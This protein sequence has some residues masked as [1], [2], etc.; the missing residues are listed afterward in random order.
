MLVVGVGFYCCGVLMI[1]NFVLVLVGTV[2]QLLVYVGAGLDFLDYFVYLF[3][4]GGDVAVSWIHSKV[5]GDW[6]GLCWLFRWFLHLLGLY[7]DCF[8]PLIVGRKI[9]SPIFDTLKYLIFSLPNLWLSFSLYFYLMRSRN[10]HFILISFPFLSFMPYLI[11]IIKPIS[12][13]TSILTFICCLS[14]HIGFY[15]MSFLLV[16]FIVIMKTI[17]WF[18]LYFIDLFEYVIS[19]LLAL[20]L[21]LSA[22]VHFDKLVL[23][24]LKVLVLLKDGCFVCLDLLWAEIDV[25]LVWG[26]SLLGCSVMGFEVIGFMLEFC[27]DALYLFYLF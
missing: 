18:L 20:S 21:F 15:F 7:F 14:T 2:G 10:L 22:S 16:S 3:A 1:L 11:T 27:E 13:D 4:F 5:L 6:Y 25:L 26:S 12:F 24:A 23:E 9:D 17:F 8:W 19:F